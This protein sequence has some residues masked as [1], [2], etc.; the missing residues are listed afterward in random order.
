MDLTKSPSINASL[1]KYNI[2]NYLDVVNYTP[3]SYEDM[4]P[5]NEFGILDKQRVVFYGTLS[6]FPT[7]SIFHHLTL[8]RFR[9]KTINNYIYNI[10]AYNRQFLLKILKLDIKYVLTG[11]YDLKKNKVNLIS[12]S[13][14][15]E[16]NNNKPKPIYSLPNNVDQLTYK[17]LVIRAFNFFNEEN[18][19]LSNIVPAYFMKK[20]HLID[21]LEALKLLHNPNSF[22]E[23]KAGLR[24]LKYEECLK[25]ALK[26]ELIRIENKKLEKNSKQH[27]LNKSVEDF[28]KTIPYKLTNSQ[29]DSLLEIIFD[30]N[31]TSL[32]YRLL[33]GDVGSGKT[34]VASLALYANYLRNDQGALMAPTD[35]LAR[36]HYATLKKLFINTKIRLALLVGETPKKERT[37]IELAIMNHKI[38]IVIGTHALF[39]KSVSYSSLGLVVIDEQHRFGVNQRLLLTNKGSHA[40]LLLMSAT[41]IPRT[42][43]LTIYG[44]L[45]VSTL[46]EFPFDNKNVNTSIVNGLDNRIYEL[47]DDSLKNNKQVYIIAP[48][49]MDNENNEK[50]TVETLYAHFLLRYPGKVAL[51]HGKLKQEEK[52]FALENFKNNK[53]PIIVSTTVIEV[54]L[55]I[56]SANLMIIYDANNF[57]LASLHQLRGR[58]GRDGSRANCLLVYD[59]N[60]IEDIDRLEV[61]T[62]SNDGFYIANEDLKRRGPGELGGIRQSGLPSFNFVNLVKD[63]RIFECAREDAKFICKNKVEMGFRKILKL[64]SEE[65][66]DHNFTSFA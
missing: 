64:A 40:D 35:A 47:I 2:N 62:K 18:H 25:F 61:L 32:M 26:T 42:L 7:L 54:G 65:I 16:I 27:I 37:Q 15:D 50:M 46:K 48:L 45:D 8:V 31:K 9:F 24:V 13:R 41:P 34:L 57:G 12:I 28:I 19:Y 58:I 1:K 22:N 5:T 23:I 29:N 49:I 21:R 66:K 11:I 39:S 55:D 51:L 63:F 33:Q 10:E 52:L 4:S 20:Y 60:D 53:Y 14:Y 6:S 56:K 36:Q 38:D 43:A 44:D 30:M 59:G 3:R 17:R